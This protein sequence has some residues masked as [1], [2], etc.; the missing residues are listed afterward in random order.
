[1][2]PIK[3]LYCIPSSFQVN[4]KEQI[5]SA[6]FSHRFRFVAKKLVKSKT[7]ALTITLS[8]LRTNST[9][10]PKHTQDLVSVWPSYRYITRRKI[11]SISA[12]LSSSNVQ[13]TM[14]QNWQREQSIH[15]RKK[16]H[17]YWRTD[18]K[19][20][21]EIDVW[22]GEQKMVELRI[23]LDILPLSGAVFRYAGAQRL[24]LLRSPLLFRIPHSSPSLSLSRSLVKPSSALSDRVWFWFNSE[25][26]NEL[27][28]RRRLTS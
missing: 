17:I 11:L 19:R 3:K 20:Y 24:L 4:E 7:G 22:A 25:V 21:L 6:P 18:K 23:L 10:P 14:Q 5:K 16:P 9:P 8:R 13:T 2:P 1:M 12:V 28:K 27:L 15:W 26:F